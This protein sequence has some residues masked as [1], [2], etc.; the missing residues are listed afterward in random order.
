MP[1]TPKILITG[2]SGLLGA[3]LALHYADKSDCTGWFS[4]NPISIE[5]VTTQ[6]VDLTDHAKTDSALQQIKPDLIIHCAASSD[7]DW[8]EKHPELAR[9]INEDATE[10]LAQKSVEFG[11]KFVFVSSPFIFD[12]IVG[13]YD[14]NDPT[15]P[16]NAYASSKVRAEQ[17]VID[18]STNALII[19]ACFYGNSPS[20][21]HSIM[22]WILGLAR[23]GKD[24]PG[25]TDSYFSPINVFD[26]AEAL[27][28]AIAVDAIGVLHFGSRN[29][30][31]KYEF[32]RMVLEIFNYDV[33]LLRPITVDDARL[34]ANRPRDTSLNVSKLE[35]IQQQPAPTVA[36]GL[37]RFASQ[38]NPFTR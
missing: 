8:S 17:K 2:A 37:K 20:G 21:N 18:A 31:S 4:T 14:E 33:G 13:N 11:S 32:A 35:R 10:F 16:L 29:T 7:V 30:V 6:Q 23:D 25:F 3:N 15:G 38:P 34:S 26:L 5:G 19:R 12:G 28:S 1:E 36:D 9:A 22:E 27:D 24:V